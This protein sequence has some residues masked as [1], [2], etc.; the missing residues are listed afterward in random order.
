MDKYVLNVLVE[1]ASRSTT[2]QA[3]VFFFNK[4]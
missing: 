2:N 1:I 3:N 4:K